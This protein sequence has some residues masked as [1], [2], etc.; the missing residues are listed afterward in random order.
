[1]L[2]EL[3]ELQECCELT[4]KFSCLQT[5]C[6]P[7]DSV[8]NEAENVSKFKCFKEFEIVC[9]LL[10]RDDYFEMLEVTETELKLMY[11]IN[12]SKKKNSGIL[13]KA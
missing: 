8:P 4:F 5:Y 10:D 12:C 11:E 9:T 2:Y 3:L 7:P 13:K 1:L 6:S